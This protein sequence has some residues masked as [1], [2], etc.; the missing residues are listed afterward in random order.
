MSHFSVALEL[1]YFYVWGNPVVFATTR[2]NEHTTPAF[3]PG[4]K[5]PVS[6]GGDSKQKHESRATSS[7]PPHWLISLKGDGQWGG[8]S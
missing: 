6:D 3:T 5:S 4:Y 8:S 1:C 2:S 7:S